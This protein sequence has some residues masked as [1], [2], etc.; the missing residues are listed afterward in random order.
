M[1]ILEAERSKYE[2]IWTDVPEYRDYSPGLENVQHFLDVLSPKRGQSLI[3][4]GCGAGVAGLE[5]AAHGLKVSY[6]DITDA[7]L[8]PEVPRERFIK[9]ALW[10]NWFDSAP[11]AVEL[12]V[13]S[14]FN[15]GYC[16][17]VMEHIPTEFAMLVAA[18]IIAACDTTWFQIAFFHDGHGAAIGKP[19][20]LT[21]QPF[22]WWLDRLENIGDVIDARDLCGRGMFIVRRK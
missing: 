22:E 5:F 4:I 17:D 20:H 2:Q 15:Y 21:V 12:D 18:R 16:C 7:A 13:R 8:L 6:L 9:T 10:D 11:I 1:G 19:L 3:D 14:G